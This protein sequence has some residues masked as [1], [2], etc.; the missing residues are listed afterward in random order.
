M[1]D[2]IRLHIKRLV[3]SA[4]FLALCLLLPFVTG[5]IQKFGQMLAPMHIPV[6]L[7]GI[8]CGPIWGAAVGFIAPLLRY[9]LF[10]MPIIYPMGI[11]MAFELATYGLVIGLLYMALNKKSWGSMVSL[12]GAMICGRA[13]WGIARL[14]LA[15]LKSTPFTLEMFIAGAFTTA[16]PGIICQILLIPLIVALLKKFKLIPLK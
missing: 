2:K 13:V 9:M 16:I 12:I 11:S 10:G 4:M 8:V 3:L 6:L 1:Y 7:C 14:V 5:Q 15:G